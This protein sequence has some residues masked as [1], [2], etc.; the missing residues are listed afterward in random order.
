MSLQGCQAMQLHTLYRLRNSDGLPVR[1]MLQCIP[2]GDPLAALSP[3]MLLEEVCLHLRRPSVIHVIERLRH[4]ET[5]AHKTLAPWN[6]RWAGPWEDRMQ[7][8]SEPLLHA[9]NAPRCG[10]LKRGK[11]PH[12]VWHLPGGPVFKILGKTRCSPH[13]VG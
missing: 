10:M 8:T 7:R 11:R 4:T 2:Q 6:L 9:Q 5:L 1:L 3:V 12:A 13:L